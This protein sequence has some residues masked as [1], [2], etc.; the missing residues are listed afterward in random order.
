MIS[1]KFTLSL[2]AHLR[3]GDLCS[4]TMVIWAGHLMIFFGSRNAQ[5][6]SGDLIAILFGCSTPIVIRPHGKYFKVVG[7][8]YVQ[9]L[10]DGKAMEMLE[11]GKVKARS[12]TFC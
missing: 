3:N 1:L 5:T 2:I 10:M 12:F 8:A 6:K 9:G 4:L 11:S 7:E